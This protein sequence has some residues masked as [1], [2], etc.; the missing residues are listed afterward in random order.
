MLTRCKYIYSFQDASVLFT[1]PISNQSVEKASQRVFS[2][3]SVSRSYTEIKVAPTVLTAQAALT[4]VSI[5][6]SHPCVCVSL[7]IVVTNPL[8]P[9]TLW[10]LVTDSHSLKKRSKTKQQ[11]L[12]YLEFLVSSNA[13]NGLFSLLVNFQV[14]Q[15]GFLSSLSSMIYLMRSVFCPS[16]PQLEILIF[17]DLTFSDISTPAVLPTNIYLLTPSRQIKTQY[18]IY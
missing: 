10:S 11:R 18:M 4:F 1:H 15:T 3:W 16:K 14:F 12:R 6:G 17:Q 7:W 5:K 13:T 8:S 9:P 2:L